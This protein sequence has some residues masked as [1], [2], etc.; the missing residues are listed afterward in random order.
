M[1]VKIGMKVYHEGDGNGTVVQIAPK[2]KDFQALVK[3]GKCH[4]GWFPFKQLEKA[5]TES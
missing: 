3:F 1:K 2:D 4:L 5:K